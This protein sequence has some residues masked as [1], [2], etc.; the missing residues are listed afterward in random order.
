MVLDFRRLTFVAA[1][2]LA[3]WLTVVCSVQAQQGRPGSRGGF[4]GGFG[5]FGRGSEVPGNDW[6]GLLQNE[7]VQTEIDLLDDQKTEIRKVN[8]ESRERM[9]SVFQGV[10]NFR[11]ASEEEREKMQREMG[12][13]MQANTK[14]TVKRLEGI[15]LPP[16]TA[17]LKEISLQVR[18]TGALSDPEVEKQLGISA[19]QKEQ[20]EK[21]REEQGEKMRA[22]FTGDNRDQAREKMTELRKESTDRTLAVLSAEQ[23]DKLE[24]MKGKPIDADLE[25][26]RRGGFGGAAGGRGT[27]GPGGPGGPGGQQ[28]RRPGGNNN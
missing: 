27:G 5:G 11:E 8:D 21:V 7:K 17:R 24:K 12:E 4:S 6:I 19:Q 3:A 22:L 2:V 9:R 14:E 18:G 15:L 13:K 28:R 1:A 23:R 20:L 16:Q 10:G 25:E 26:L